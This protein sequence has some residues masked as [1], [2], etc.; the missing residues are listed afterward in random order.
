MKLNKK[1]IIVG[2][3]T[4]PIPVV[5]DNGWGGIENILTSIVQELDDRGINYT[6]VNDKDNYIQK[7]SE[8][9]SKSD[10]IIHCHFD[11][12][13]PRIKQVF[14]G[15]V[16][17]VAT[18][19]SPFHSFEE[20][21]N[22][23]VRNHFETL[24]SNIDAYFGQGIEANTIAKK[25]NPNLKF[26]FCRCC[27][28]E[29]KFVQNRVA[30]GNG[31]TLMLG[32]IEPRKNQALIRSH[33]K[34]LPIDFIGAIADQNFITDEIYGNT[35]YLGCWSRNQVWTNMSKYSSLMCVSQFE[36]DVVVVK[37]AIASGC[38]LILSPFSAINIDKNWSFVKILE[39]NTNSEQ[40]RK[41]IYDINF[42]NFSL[43]EEIYKKF[44]TN[45]SKKV[46]VDEYLFG[47][48]EA[49]NA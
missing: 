9:V 47:L 13:A 46:V 44:N 12:Y 21:W 5:G 31:R 20:T 27:V 16:P 32:K 38:S 2:P 14:G 39:N 10:C 18:S 11:D 8:E 6:L 36:G 40:F 43:R 34:D 24:F 17:I 30:T 28:S 1:L 49:F 7:I 42:N 26:G 25:M 37:E 29:E 45:F 22:S 48:K 35:K 3:G 19:H 33:F 4:L 23:G 15:K 41:T